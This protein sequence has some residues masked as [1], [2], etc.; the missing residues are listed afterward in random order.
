[1]GGRVLLAQVILEGVGEFAWPRG[2]HDRVTRNDRRNL[3]RLE[4][5]ACPVA[6]VSYPCFPPGGCPCFP[7]GGCQGLRSLY[8]RVHQASEQDLLEVQVQSH[9]TG[10][11]SHPVQVLDALAAPGYCLAE[12]RGDLQPLV[13]ACSGSSPVKALSSVVA[14]GSH[15]AISILW[16][17]TIERR[18]ALVAVLMAPVPGLVAHVGAVLKGPLPPVDRD[19]PAKAV[20]RC[21]REL[22]MHPDE[23]GGGVC[24]DQQYRAAQQLGHNW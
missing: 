2:Q 21:G 22:Y 9:D 4:V 12:Y 13:P 16:L 10:S 3:H 17:P 20:C 11:M 15:A 18:I 19:P 6:T 7:P 23:G 14:R 5:A 1:M 24:V 8:S